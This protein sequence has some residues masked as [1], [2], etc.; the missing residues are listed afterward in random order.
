MV[1][2][3]RGRALSP[4]EWEFVHE[5]AA[6]DGEITLTEAARRANMKPSHL[7][8]ISKDPDVLAAMEETREKFRKKYATSYDKHMRALMDIRD[9]ALAAGAYSA[10]VQ[11]EYRRGMALGTIYVDRKEIRV[12]SIDSMSREEVERRLNE[13]KRTLEGDFVRE[14]VHEIKASDLEYTKAFVRIQAVPPREDDFD[15][16]G[17]DCD[18][19]GVSDTT[20]D[21]RS[22][23]RTERDIHDP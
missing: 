18:D 7:R 16:A 22:A 3:K 2:E 17:S 12:G 5:W 8:R 10:A 4:R 14:K 15:C 21:P 9:R 19:A 23:D 1:E 11:A 13:L 6:T 20:G